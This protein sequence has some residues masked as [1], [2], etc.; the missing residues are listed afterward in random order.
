MLNGYSAW[1]DRSYLPEVYHP[2]ETVNLGIVGEAEARVLRR[3]RVRQVILDQHAFPLKVSAFGPTLTRAHLRASPYLEPLD[4]PAGDWGLHQFRVRETP[5]PVASAPPPTSPLGVFWEAES[6]G[7]ETGRIT[8][9]PDASNGHVNLARNGVDR[10]GFI[11]FGPYR[12]LPPGTY[13]ARFR[14]KGV[15][16]L[17]EPHVTTRGGREILGRLRVHLADGAFVEVT[18]PFTLSAPAH[19]EYR[20]AWDGQGWAAVDSVAVSF[21]AE[22]DPVS[23]F[24]VEVMGHELHE[25]ADPHASGGAAG[26]AIPGRTPRGPV[27]SGPLRRYPPGRYRLWIRVKLDHAV[28]G[29]FARC[30]AEL[31]S[32]SGALGGRDLTGPEVPEPGR[33]VELAVPFTVERP[34]VLEFPCA[35]QGSAGVWFDRLRVERL[36]GPA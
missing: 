4:T 8:Q 32:Q 7:R 23:V 24:E 11:T 6:L 34:A 3:Y 13:Q 30:G 31:A 18:V 20:T 17:V 26:Y 33:Y 9:D 19:L 35:F 21:T 16:S 15:G 10:P 36:E 1:L 25:R 14:I 5:R 27:W 28:T 12:I 22:P 2:L 29:A